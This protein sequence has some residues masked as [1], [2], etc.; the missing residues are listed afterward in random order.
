MRQPVSEVRL[1]GLV[2]WLILLYPGTGITWA[3]QFNIEA[4][5]DRGLT[6][7][8]FTSLALDA[9]S[10]PRVISNND[11]TNRILYSQ[12]QAGSW[13]IEV[14]TTLSISTTAPYSSLALDQDG[15]AHV[16]YYDSWPRVL[17]YAGKRADAWAIE[18]VDDGDA[19]LVAD[20]GSASHIS[21]TTD[22]AGNPHVAYGN[23]T[24]LWLDLRY[25]RKLQ[26]AWIVERVGL[27]GRV[28]EYNSLALDA[29]GAPH[30]SCW[31]QSSGTLLYARKTGAGWL[32][33]VVDQGGSWSSLA[34]DAQGNAHISYRSASGSDL[35]YAR[36]SGGHWET[37]VA[38]ALETDAGFW[39]GIDLDAQGNPHIFHYDIGAGDLRYVRKVG[40]AWLRELVDGATE[41]A[42]L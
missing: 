7:G 37:E 4:V 41:D 31:D 33:E 9:E 8:L 39:T 21:I 14:V 28:G 24:W 15:N 12:K 42:G 11:V 26:G 23:P 22:L 16:C 13:A 17:R 1:L 10:N 29:N 34:I 30:I 25:A 32:H 19:A 27:P 6:T 2:S 40:G 18:L 35:K 3:T 36:K 20:A 38:E 5:E